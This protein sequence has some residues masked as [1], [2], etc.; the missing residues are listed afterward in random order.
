MALVAFILLIVTGILAGIFFIDKPIKNTV[1]DP[2]TVVETMETLEPS[3]TLFEETSTTVV[4]ATTEAPSSTTTSKPKTTT[5]L[6]T[7]TSK[8]KPSTTT[9][10]RPK[11]TTTTSIAAKPSGSAGRFSAQCRTAKGRI[12]C[13]DTRARIMGAFKDG[14]LLAFKEDIVAGCQGTPTPMGWSALYFPDESWGKPIRESDHA[15]WSEAFL[16]W[17]PYFIGFGNPDYGAGTH[18]SNATKV[19]SNGCIRN[20]DTEKAKAFYNALSGGGRAYVY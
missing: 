16:V 6:M 14:E 13:V 2:T 7:T 11:T 20:T 17:M 8:P 12:L 5:T 4:T 9:T 10:T 19:C 3:T 15:W 18:Y 1:V